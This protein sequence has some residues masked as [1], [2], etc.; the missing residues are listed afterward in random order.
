MPG[1]DDQK[2]DDF[3][4]AMGESF[5]DSICPPVPN[6]EASPHECCNAVCSVLGRNVTPTTLARLSEVRLVALAIGIGEY[7][8]CEAPR[9][10]QVEDAIARTLDRW[11]AGSLGE[12]E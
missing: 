10:E 3:I 5:S 1:P 12:S 4:V 7:F 11:P 9:E 8:E 2:R 6:E